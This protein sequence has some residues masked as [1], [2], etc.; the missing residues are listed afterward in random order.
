MIGARTV[1]LAALAALTL[2][3]GCGHEETTGPCAT[4]LPVGRITGRVRIGGDDPTTMVVEAERVPLP[5]S[6]TSA[7]R[8]SP[9]ADGYY[10]LDVPAGRYCLRIGY[11]WSAIGEE[12]TLGD[13]DFGDVPPDTLQVDAEHS[14]VVDFDL[15]RMGIHLDLPRAWEG[16]DWS[17]YLY[18][19]G[20]PARS[21]WSAQNKPEITDGTLDLTLHALF[22]GAYRVLMYVAA[23]HCDCDDCWCDGESFWLPGTR[24][25]SAAPWIEV[26]PNATAEVSCGIG[27]ERPARIEGDVTGAW[28]EMGLSNP[29]KLTLL[30]PDSLQVLGPWGVGA[31]GHFAVEV[32]LPGPVKARV[33]QNGIEQWIG[34]EDFAHA[35]VFPLESGHTISGVRLVQSGLRV[36][37]GGPW[38]GILDARIQLYDPADLRLVAASGRLAGNG[39]THGLVNLR[40]GIYLVLL[41]RGAWWYDSPAW[42]PQ[43]FDRAVHPRDATPVTISREGEIV[44][45]HVAPEAG[46]TIRGTIS[47]PVATGGTTFIRYAVYLTPADDPACLGLTEGMDAPLRYEMAGVPNGDWK[48]G[49]LGVE[50]HLLDDRHAPA[51]PPAGTVWYPGTTDWN[52]AGTVTVRDLGAVDGIDFSLP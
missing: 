18:R 44:T 29:P 36:Q 50:H 33:D 46:G 16:R 22:P 48:V 25:S 9:G 15:G 23:D 51:Q 20:N 24:D 42:S 12:Y 35:E 21:V 26:A 19:R 1:A 17:L 28:L 14:P 40:P 32:Y 11:D 7:F 47:A 41:T 6:S 5:P 3:A 37:F 8:A 30:T 34:G 52:A 27:V 43:W 49:I 39:L 4:A 38:L 10:R 31:D 45:L 2:A 13:R